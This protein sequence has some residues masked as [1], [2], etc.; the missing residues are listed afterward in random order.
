[1]EDKLLSE[2]LNP[3]LTS[4]RNFREFTRRPTY[5]IETIMCSYRERFRQ[6]ILVVYTEI[7]NI[8]LPD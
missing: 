1:M 5:K 8:D 7:A 4:G 6:C 3:S 2:Y